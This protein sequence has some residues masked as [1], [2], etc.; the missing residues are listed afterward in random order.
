MDADLNIYDVGH[1]C[2]AHPGWIS[3]SGRPSVATGGRST[4]R[5][6]AMKT[7]LRR[8]IATGVPIGSLVKVLVAFATMVLL[9][10][11]HPLQSGISRV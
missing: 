8:A 4:T 3:A 2:M 10:H 9:E 5:R 7:L 11:V 6:N 1:V